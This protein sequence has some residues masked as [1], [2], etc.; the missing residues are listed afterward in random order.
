MQYLTN[1][2]FTLDHSP[3]SFWGTVLGYEKNCSILCKLYTVLLDTL[4]VPT[5]R[6]KHMVQKHLI[7][8]AVNPQRLSW[9]PNTGSS[10]TNRIIIP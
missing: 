1:K 6:K 3:S 2:E 9:H 5:T 8:C 4:A 10:L 7:N